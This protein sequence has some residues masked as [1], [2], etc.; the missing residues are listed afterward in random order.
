MTLVQIKRRYTQMNKPLSYLLKLVL[1]LVLLLLGNAAWAQ[2]AGQ[3]Y[4]PAT[5][6]TAQAIMDPNGDGFVSKDR[7]G[8]PIVSS[9]DKDGASNMEL[10]MIRVPYFVKDP[11]GHLD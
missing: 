10:P 3:I 2:T 7:T 9:Q 1:P 6:A 4:L 8:F 5:D 11:I